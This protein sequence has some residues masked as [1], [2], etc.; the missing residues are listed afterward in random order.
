MGIGKDK[1]TNHPS[2]RDPSESDLRAFGSRE[3]DSPNGSF[4]PEPPMALVEFSKV[5]IQPLPVGD[6]SVWR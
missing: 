1:T 4:Q 5:S 3:S 6:W 2:L